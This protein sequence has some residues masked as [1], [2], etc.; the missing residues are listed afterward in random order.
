MQYLY[1]QELDLPLLGPKAVSDYE[2]EHDFLSKFQNNNLMAVQLCVLADRLMIPELQN[3][4]V[5]WI[6]DSQKLARTTATTC[7]NYVYENID[8]S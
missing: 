6:W 1:K 4:I 8:C 7:L 2:S 3:R 5:A